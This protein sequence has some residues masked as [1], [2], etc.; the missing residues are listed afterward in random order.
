VIT[1]VN[2][3]KIIFVQLVQIEEKIYLHVLVQMD[4][5]IILLQFVNHVVEYVQ[6]V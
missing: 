2:Y 3:V 6:L 5:L 1:N 4:S